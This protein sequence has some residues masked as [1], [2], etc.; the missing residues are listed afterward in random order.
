MIAPV[1]MFVAVF[2]LLLGFAGFVVAA[3]ALIKYA[4]THELSLMISAV[5][6]I[7]GAIAML[8]HAMTLLHHFS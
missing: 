5:A 4:K 1:T 7:L 2:C 3:F 6:L 8:V